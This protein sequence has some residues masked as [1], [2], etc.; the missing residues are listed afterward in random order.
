M[1]GQAPALRFDP[2]VP[3]AERARVVA[4][5][6]DRLFLAATRAALLDGAGTA[7][8]HVAPFHGDPGSNKV[9]YRV[10]VEGDGAFLL[11]TAARGGFWHL[12]PKGTFKHRE[13]AHLRALAGTGLTPRF[14]A[15]AVAGDREAYSEELIEG[16]TGADPL[17]AGDPARA[18][19]LAALWLRIARRLTPGGGGLLWRV[20]GSTMAP[21][22]AM[23]RVRDGAPCGPPVVVD[24]GRVR[25][26]T[27]RRILSKLLRDHGDLAAV[28]AGIAD[29]LGPAAAARFEAVARWQLRLARRRTPADA[30]LLRALA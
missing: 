27:P 24:V 17:V 28:R 8:L 15:H 18:R 23:Y 19:E 21:G 5:L 7:A 6:Q 25:W 26:R 22:N 9:L 11:K 4:F 29:A 30:A 10:S 2:A 1:D 14:G 12:R 13:V 20:P 3:D 16:V